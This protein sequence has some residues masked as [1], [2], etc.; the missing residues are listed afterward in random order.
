MA[1]SLNTSEKDG[2]IDH[3]PSN[4]YHMMQRLWKSV[5]RILRYFGSERT[6]PVRNKNGCHGDVPWDMEKNSDLSSTP[7]TLA[8]GIKIAK[9]ARGLCFAYNTKLV[10]MATSLNESKKR[11]GS[12]K[13]TQIPF[14][15]W[16][17]RENRSSISWDNLSQIKKKKLTQAIY[18]ALSANL[19]S[20]LKTL[21]K[22]IAFSANLP[23]GL[24]KYWHWYLVTVML[25]EFTLL[26]TII[27]L[28]KQLF[29]MYFRINH[30]PFIIDISFPCTM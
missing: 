22:Y 28:D 21:A 4:T 15:W 1:T 24:N 5:Q 7:K 14:F 25:H 23:S 8:Y 17:D 9:I 18:V 29:Y 13:C 27:I 30:K 20:R 26:V 16:K 12:R 6:S 10:A 2:R 11:S 3:L 19:P